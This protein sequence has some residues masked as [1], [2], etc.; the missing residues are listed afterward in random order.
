VRRGYFVQGLLGAQF[1]LPD[2]V[3]RLRE[4][5]NESA[6]PAVVMSVRDPANAYRWARAMRSEDSAVPAP[7]LRA[8]SLVVT[9]S[10]R[11]ILVAEA[12]AE[13]VRLMPNVS[14]A[15]LSAAAQ[16]LTRH[17]R[18]QAA[19]NSASLREYRIRQ[20]DD[21]SAVR[22]AATAAFVAAG[23]RQVGLELI[24]DP[25]RDARSPSGAS[26]A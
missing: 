8:R 12:R 25:R 22:N 13:R 24:F 5:A 4:T 18:Q 26:P 14:P 17:L 15:A 6:P 20:I 10:G 11:P 7:L 9:R 21:A 3:E 23:W 2:A 19:N 16:S 1:A